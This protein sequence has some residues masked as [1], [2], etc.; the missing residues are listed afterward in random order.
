M[1]AMLFHITDEFGHR[2]CDPMM[3]PFVDLY[4]IKQTF[5]CEIQYGQ[6]ILY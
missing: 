1:E 5:L 3:I 6:L 2:L 4:W